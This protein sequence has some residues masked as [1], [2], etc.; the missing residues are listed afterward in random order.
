MLR[1]EIKINKMG[2]KITWRMWLCIAFILAALISIFSIPPKFLESGVSVKGVEENTS[3]FNSG[4]RAG[5]TITAINN[6]KVSSMQEYSL[7]MSEY[8]N[9]KE[10]ET[11]KISITTKQI[12]IISLV[13]KNIISQISVADIQKTRINT[14]LD[15]RGGARALVTAK[16]YKLSETELDD[17]ISVSQERLNVY[18]L[19]DITL[20]KQSDISGNKY[21]VVEIAG[22]SPKDLEELLGKQG[23]FEA[24][25]GNETVFSGGK[26]DITYVGRSGQDAGVYD[27]RQSATDSWV[28]MFRFSISLSPSASEHYGEVTKDIPVNTS[29]PGYLEKTID[30]Y[31]DDA[32][33]DSLLI[34][35]DLKG[36]TTTQHSIQGSGTGATSQEAYE[37]AKLNMK[38]LQTVLITGSLP[39]KLE[40]VKIDRISPFLGNNF[41]RTILIAGIFAF[42]SVSVIVFLRYRKIKISLIMLSIVA[43]EIIMVLGFMALMNANLDLAGIAGI[44]AAIGTGVDDQ[45]VIVDESRRGK[46]ETMKQRIK[47][48]LFIVFV[49]F[50]TAIA[51]LFPLFYAGAGLLKGFALTSLAGIV[52][53]VFI[54]RPAFADIVNQLE[55]N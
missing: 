52:G 2:L 40:I 47:N 12:E 9:L 49:A 51:S 39:F 46:E 31:L 16:D 27:C 53:G 44:I 35:V 36:S 22:S 20:R 1:L 19:S 21:M 28:C 6:Q 8:S 37:S 33:T 50:A 26:A 55:E 34:S 10:N 5:M 7:A 48:A 24:K 45:L 42:L 17:L 32:L 13:D 30:F 23:K 15:I 25:I 38:K 29:N 14:G 54:T 3:I 18:G 41:T 11:K 43:A 4:L